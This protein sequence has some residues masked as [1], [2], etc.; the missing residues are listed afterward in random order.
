MDYLV[1]PVI[2]YSLVALSGVGVWLTLPRKGFNPQI[3]GGLIAGIAVGGIM[4]ALGLAA[5]DHAPNLFF[6]V[7]AAVALGAGLRM[8][9]HPR[10]VYAA[11]FFI[12]TILASAGMYLL[13]SA[14]FMAFAL[15][16]V[17]AGAILITYLFVI[18]LAT[19]GQT[20]DEE[21]A[22][23]EEY[24][25]VAREPGSA[26]LIGFVL[27]AMFSTMLGRG[28]ESLPTPDPARVDAVLGMMPLKIERD[29]KRDGLIE[30]DEKVAGAAGVHM[31]TRTVDVT[32]P[33]GGREGVAMPADLHASNVQSVG[34]VLL[35]QHPGAIEIAGVILLMAMLGAVVLARKKVE[36]EDQ[37]KLDAARLMREGGSL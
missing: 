25:K 22:Q 32:S 31:E 26:V 34:F 19:Q 6:Y 4:L 8:I 21:Q 14:E 15:I 9:T 23:A 18:M 24:D 30:A 36:I 33:R 35:G 13:L 11:L 37:A 12:L 29:M 20:E 1:N 16:I 28:M 7:F 5:G 3:L 27:L 17:Y 10:P 2:L